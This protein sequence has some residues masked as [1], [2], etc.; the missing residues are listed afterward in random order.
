M[1]LVDVFIVCFPAFMLG[2]FVGGWLNRA[3]ADR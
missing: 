2:V 1:V 3:G